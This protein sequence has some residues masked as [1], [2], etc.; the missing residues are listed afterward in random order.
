MIETEFTPQN[1][2]EKKLL[3][4]LEG[5]LAGD[6]FITHLLNSQVFMPIQDE[7]AV[8]KGFQRAT[9]TQPLLLDDEEGNQV[10]VL[11]TSPERAREF[12]AGYPDYGGGLLTEFSWILSK[13]D[14]P[15]HVSLNPDIDTGLDLDREMVEDLMTR[16]P[17][18]AA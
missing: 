16:L 6:V 7:P 10:L 17:P 9:K 1:E 13:L 3:S 2:L 4:A 14:D 12:V 18:Q 5:T 11:F 8:I 15:M